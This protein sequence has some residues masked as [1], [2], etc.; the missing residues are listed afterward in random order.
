M[1]T[2]RGGVRP[3]SN[4][5]FFEPFPKSMLIK[6]YRMSFLKIKFNFDPS[7]YVQRT[8]GSTKK[9]KF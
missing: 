9:Q 8:V 4:N 5:F 7:T 6:D 2:F 1:I 3:K